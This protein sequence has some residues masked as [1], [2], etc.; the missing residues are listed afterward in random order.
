MPY[1]ASKI[2]YD[3]S[4]Y[5]AVPKETFPSCKGRKT[6]RKSNRQTEQR[7]AK[8]WNAYAER[9]ALPETRTPQTRYGKT[10]G[11]FPSDKRAEGIRQAANGTQEKTTH[12]SGITRL[13]HKSVSARQLEFL[14]NVYLF[15][16]KAHGTDLSKDIA[17]HFETPCK[18][19]RLEVYRRVGTL[20][21]RAA[22]L[23]RDILYPRKRYGG[24]LK[25]VSDYSTKQHRMQTTYQNTHFL[26]YF[27]RND[28]KAIDKND[29]VQ[30]GPLSSQIH[31]EKRRKI[32][33]RRRFAYLF[34]VWRYG[35]GYCLP[36]GDRRQKSLVIRR[37]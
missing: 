23:S 10:Q 25:Q 19:Q 26:R 24:E 15:R 36:Y 9:Q 11:D 5:I 30:S 22:T 27:G 32:G 1:Q 13:W 34:Q 20:C 8:C 29:V 6:A 12:I 21:K 35:R 16:R 17:Q 37:L 14:C 7:K 31:R 33:I 3:G 2:Y 28:F 4:H 18:P